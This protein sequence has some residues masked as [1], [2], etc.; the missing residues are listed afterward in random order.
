MRATGMLMIVASTLAATAGRAAVFT[1]DFALGVK[2][3][4]WSI[5]SNQ[6]LFTWDDSAGDVL[7]T[8]PIGGSGGLDFIALRL[9][10]VAYGDFDL[11]VDF[12]QA[13]IDHLT[14]AIGNQV[15]LNARF[16]SQLLH[17]VRSDE[18][19][20][21]DNAHLFANPPFSWVGGVVN[22][23]A[24]GGTLRLTRI[25]AQVTARFGSTIIHQ[26]TYNTEPLSEVSLSLQCNETLDAISVRFDDFSLTADT[27]LQREVFSD[28][29]ESGTTSAWS[30]TMP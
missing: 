7:L 23:A 13:S 22:T 21:G 17:V 20:V 27:I 4:T 11:Q 15:Q 8:K 5:L 25:G 18:T 1:D 3:Q 6:P 30:S 28:G 12:S 16:G 10:R 26:G 2:P 19:A 29:F 24:S 14:G 9:E